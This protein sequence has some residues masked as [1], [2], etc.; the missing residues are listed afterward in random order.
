MLPI[1]GVVIAFGMREWRREVGK[2]AMSYGRGLGTGLLITIWS[3]LFS[4]VFQVIYFIFI[5]PGYSE[6]LY[7]FQVAEMERKGMAEDVI[8]KAEPAMRFMMSTPMLI[9]FGVIGAIFFGLV[10]SLI[11][12]AV[13]KAEASNAPVPP[14]AEA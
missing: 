12:A 11:L 4:I 6:A 2:G 8:S 1:M 7:Q 14:P 5:N 10:L 13:F 9:V 3:T